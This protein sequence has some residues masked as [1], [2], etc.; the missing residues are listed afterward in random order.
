MAWKASE[1]LMETIKH[2][3]SFPAT[4]VSLRQMV[5]FGE[6]PSTGY[7]LSYRCV[8]FL[9]SGLIEF[10]VRYPFPCISIPRRRASYTSGP[11]GARAWRATRWTKRYAVDQK[12]AGLVRAVV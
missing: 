6:R 8:I 12:S 5:Q 2:Y 3:S 10:L 4:G 1:V 7:S 9:N 11:S